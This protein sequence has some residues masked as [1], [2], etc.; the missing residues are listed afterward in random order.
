M[1][2]TVAKNFRMSPAALK[3]LGEIAARNGVTETDVV[4][5]C[6]ARYAADLEIEVAAATALLTQQIARTI[7]AG[8]RREESPAKAGANSGAPVFASDKGAAAALR[9]V[10]PGPAR[11]P[12]VAAPSAPASRPSSTGQ[13]R[14]TRRQSPPAPVPK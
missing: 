11:K 6:I 5:A 14:P 12:G 1:A 3:L 8:R 4:E 10:S 2:N 9:A 7:S 13:K